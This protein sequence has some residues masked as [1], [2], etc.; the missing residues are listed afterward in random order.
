MKC[1]ALIL[2]TLL[3]AGVQPVQAARKA[4]Q[5][6]SATKT[7]EPNVKPLLK[8]IESADWKEVDTQLEVSVQAVNE[9]TKEFSPLGRAY[10]EL[11]QNK[12]ASNQLSR[13][14][15]GARTRGLNKIISLLEEQG[16]TLIYD[17]SSS[18][19]KPAA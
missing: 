17:N 4:P 13:G 2:L 15:K 12:L 16:A 11:R 3:C 7:A 14:E 18:G 5:E 10:Y 9:H 19:G 6:A 8:A 1:K